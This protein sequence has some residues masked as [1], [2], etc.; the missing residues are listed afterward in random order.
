MHSQIKPTSPQHLT[1]TLPKPRPRSYFLAGL[2]IM[3]AP[4]LVLAFQTYR[5]E[6]GTQLRLPAQI[7]LIKPLSK[8]VLTTPLNTI[9]TRKVTGHN[10]FKIGQDIFVFLSPGPND[11]WYAYAVSKGSSSQEC[12]VQSCLVLTGKVRKIDQSTLHIRYQYEDYTLSRSALKSLGES[13]TEAFEIILSVGRDGSAR[14]RQLLQ[15]GTIVPQ[16]N[17]PIPEL[18][19]LSQSMASGAPAK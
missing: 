7:N 8:Y 17:I 4:L 6:S 18:L 12:K 11:I 1:P 15:N 5:M 14:V 9:D 3:I 10:H 2:F 13:Q 16:P 19:G